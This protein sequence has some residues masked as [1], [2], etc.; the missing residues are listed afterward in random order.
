MMFGRPILEKLY[1]LE[2]LCPKRGTLYG[3]PPIVQQA[4]FN[5]VRLAGRDGMVSFEGPVMI[6]GN[7]A[8]Y[9]GGALWNKGNVSLPQD[10][11]ISG[12]TAVFVSSHAV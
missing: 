4:S 11:D 1:Q 10:A 5:D 6:T 9:Q 8:R 2:I 3:T 12:N 7:E